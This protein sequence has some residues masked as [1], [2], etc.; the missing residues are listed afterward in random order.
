MQF[1]GAPTGV[2]L[3]VGPVGASIAE[4][5]VGFQDGRRDEVPLSEGWALYEVVRANYAEGKRP[6]ELIG[7]DAS[8]QVIARKRLPWG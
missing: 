4:L 3:L 2:Q 8:G 1:G 7:L 5:Q 6:T